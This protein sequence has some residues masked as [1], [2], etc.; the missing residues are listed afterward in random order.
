MRLRWALLGL[1]LATSACSRETPN[2][3][4]VSVDTLRADALG[5]YGGPVATPTFDRLAAEGVVFERAYAPASATAPSHATLFTGQE[6][7]RHGVLRNGESLAADAMPLALR[8]RAAGF[9]TAGFASSFVLDPRFGWNTGFDHFDAAISA[10]GSTMKQKPY[11][12]AFWSAERFDGFDRRATATNDAVLRWI[13]GAREPFFLFVHYFDPHGPYVPPAVF[14]E[15]TA[16][17]RVPLD[18]RELP[19]VAPAQL[20]KLIRRYHGEVLYVDDALAA[21]TDALARKSERPSVIAV[22]AD[23]G[24][25][26]GQHRWLEHAVHLYEEQVRVPLILHAP[27]LLPAGRRIETP[28]ALADVAPTLLELAGIPADGEIDG[29]SLAAAARGGATLDER[30]IYGVR[31][32]VSEEV[33][34]DRGVELSVRKGRWKYIWASDAPHELYDLDADPNES[35]NV[36]ASQPAVAAEMLGLLQRHI[37]ALPHAR[38]AA[39]LSDETRK[40]LEALGYVE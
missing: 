26:L 11:P 18:G 25:G 24:E 39:P 20:E 30:P 17:I 10:T 15:R 22:T 8:F 13:E 14:G 16:E 27:E 6:P 7:A 2:V 23:H 32:L 31:R 28:V 36:L 1:A 5:V 37:E 19:G 35:Q 40:A 4:L 33:G 38:E 12:G 29:R 9:A 34:W 21:V 3:L